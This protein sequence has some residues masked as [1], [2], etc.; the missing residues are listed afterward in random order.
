MLVIVAKAAVIYK[1]RMNVDT[2][3]ELVVARCS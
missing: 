2:E 1:R 3:A